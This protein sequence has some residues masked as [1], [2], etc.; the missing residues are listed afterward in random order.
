MAYGKDAA[1]REKI[2]DATLEQIAREFIRSSLGGPDS[3]LAGIRERNLRAYNAQPEGEFAPPDIDD[4]STFVSSDVADTVDGMLPQLLDVFVSDD[5]AVEC[6]AKK[7]GEQAAA[8]AREATGY[9]NHLF[10]VRNDGLNILHDWFQDAALQKVGFVK[11]W[12]EEQPE[13]S[14]QTYE[15]QTQEQLAAILMDGAQL[16]GEPQ[17]DEQGGLT[18]TVVDESKRIKFNVACVAPHEMRIDPGAKWG[19]DPAAIGH[20]TQKRAFELEEM[21][22]DLSEVGPIGHIEQGDE[23]AMLGDL[24]GEP[25]H[26]LHDSHKLYDYAELYFQLDVDGDGVAEWEQVCLINGNLVSHEQTDDHPFAEIC[27]M[28]R[29]HAYFGDCPA[30]RAFL[31]QKEQTNLARALFDNVYFSVN[32]RTYINTDANVN[33]G[34]LLDNRPGGVVR[35]QGKPSDAFGAMPT[36][37]IPATAWQMQEWLSVRLEN[38]TGFTRYSQGMDADSLNKTATGINIITSKADMRLR[39][40]TRFA[41][42]GVRKMFSKLLKLA[43]K[44][45]KA[46][47]WF[48]VNGEWVPVNPYEWRDQFTMSINVGLGHGT[49]EQQ[50]QRVMAMI[51]VQ[52]MGVQMGVVGPRHIANTIR[53]LAQV[54]EFK[55]PDDFCDAQPQGLPNPEQFKQ[56]QQQMQEMG[57]K[58]QQL[59][60]EN[61]KL[62]ADAEVDRVNAAHE[63]LKAD[64]EKAQTELNARDQA[65]DAQVEAANQAQDDD[66]QQAIAA[67]QQQVATLTAVVSQLFTQQPPTDGGQGMEAPVAPNELPL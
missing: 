23:R 13:D 39:L 10:Y 7:P 38:R 28:P 41:A 66:D 8:Q 65:F 35:G 48:E 43:T 51:P 18:F 64:V 1:K 55:N 6:K 47:D 57:Q 20:V 62:K 59:E 19:D 52:Q 21:G 25:D 40:M 12:A 24:Q 46:Q 53:T 49:K 50:A 17:V 5:K 60:Q 16:A 44:H 34:D 22:Y 4:R 32:Q 14:K 2:D 33:I 67:L 37:Q 26:E 58:G 63:K 29:A 11:V 45:Q 27:F 61:I 31:I 9:L 15:G 42:L 54:N 36:E 3:E 30:D 56:M